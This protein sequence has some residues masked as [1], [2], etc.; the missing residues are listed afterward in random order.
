MDHNKNL[1]LNRLSYPGRS[2][3]EAIVKMSDIKKNK[4]C[5]TN[6]HNFFSNSNLIK[7]YLPIIDLLYGTKVLVGRSGVRNSVE[8][9]N[10]SLLRNVQSGSGADPAS[11]LTGNGYSLHRGKAVGA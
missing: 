9:R 5:L 7:I 10:L 4:N 6:V 1:N 3:S 2:S 11:C 8:T